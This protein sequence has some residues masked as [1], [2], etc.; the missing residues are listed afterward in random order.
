M[1][2]RVNMYRRSPLSLFE[3]SPFEVAIESPEELSC[4]GF[5]VVLLGTRFEKVASEME[6]VQILQGAENFNGEYAEPR[7]VRQISIKWIPYEELKGNI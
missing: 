7:K 5:E 3:V 6:K 1:L 2:D 4:L